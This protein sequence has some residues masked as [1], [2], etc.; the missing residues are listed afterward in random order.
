MRQHVPEDAY[1]ADHYYYL[2][3]VRKS[4]EF[5]CRPMTKGS[6][7]QIFV[8][9]LLSKL[10]LCSLYQTTI[11]FNMLRLICILV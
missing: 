10:L 2:A 11:F 3:I 4:S 9:E 5:Y 6:M 1:G 7:G 8:F